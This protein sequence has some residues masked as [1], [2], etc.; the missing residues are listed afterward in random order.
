M[1]EGKISKSAK[2]DES[3]KSSSSAKSDSSGSLDESRSLDENGSLDGSERSNKGSRES[4]G[5]SKSS[6]EDGLRINNG[7]IIKLIKSINGNKDDSKERIETLIQLLTIY[8]DEEKSSNNKEELK[9]IR[10]EISSMFQNEE[11]R[12]NFFEQV[13]KSTDIN[14]VYNIL[15]KDNVITGIQDEAIIN[16]IND[17]KTRNSQG[18]IM[19]VFLNEN[20]NYSVGEKFNL[21][22]QLNSDKRAIVKNYLFK[23]GLPKKEGLS[24]NDKSFAN[25]ISIM[26]NNQFLPKDIN[27]KNF[28]IDNEGEKLTYEDNNGIKFEIT[29]THT[30][31]VDNGVMWRYGSFEFNGIKLDSILD[32]YAEQ[33]FEKSNDVDAVLSVFKNY[34]NEVINDKNIKGI[35]NNII[36]RLFT[37]RVSRIKCEKTSYTVLDNILEYTEGKM[38]PTWKLETNKKQ[39]KSQIEFKKALDKDENVLLKQYLKQTNSLNNKEKDKIKRLYNSEEIEKFR[40]DYLDMNVEGFIKGF[41]NLYTLANE[42]G[43]DEKKEVNDILK[44]YVFRKVN[45][46]DYIKSQD[47]ITQLFDIFERFQIGD[48]QNTKL[49]KTQIL[50]RSLEYQLQ[51]I[52][53]KDNKTSINL[54]NL[55]DCLMNCTNIEGLKSTFEMLKSLLGEGKILNNNL[56]KLLGGESY[57]IKH[58]IKNTCGDKTKDNNDFSIDSFIDNFI[59]EFVKLDKQPTLNLQNLDE[60]TTFKSLEQIHNVKTRSDL[61]KFLEK[62]GQ[63]YPDKVDDK[64]NPQFQLLDTKFGHS[65]FKGKF[66]YPSKDNSDRGEVDMEFSLRPGRISNHDLSFGDFVR[67]TGKYGSPFMSMFMLNEGSM[68]G[69]NLKIK[70]KKIDNLKNIFEL[71]SEDNEM[72]KSFTGCEDKKQFAEQLARF[73]VL[74]KIKDEDLQEQLGEENVE[75]IEQLYKKSINH[76]EMSDIETIRDFNN[77][78]R[79]EKEIEKESHE[80]KGKFFTS[81]KNNQTQKRSNITSSN[82]SIL[83]GLSSSKVTKTS[84]NYCV[85]TSV[86][87][88]KHKNTN[89]VSI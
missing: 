13:L 25:I 87:S 57:F 14:Q 55:G 4:L 18:L 67:D 63:I 89:S 73:G 8:N 86:N 59:K 60:Q 31:S 80:S 33:L 20:N 24:E 16:L 47:N 64:L 62:Q 83:P 7:E 45:D 85:R 79:K 51:N 69:L 48:E 68:T 75:L 53:L 84:N 49:L 26:E 54:N 17:K 66:K 36:I 74:H 15:G 61:S 72:I 76:G 27:D 38:L 70:N 6:E 58:V 19:H 82:G 5:G 40:D 71:F 42:L 29:V 34:I 78:L 46:D 35:D 11:N 56:L 30:A 43:N 2:S 22:K 44:N 37:D 81:L 12:K 1:A 10:E 9:E 41:S 32:K 65:G 88:E 28:S 21:Y 3:E 39:N 52:E 77:K 23:E 50:I